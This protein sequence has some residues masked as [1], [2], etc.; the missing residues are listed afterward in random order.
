MMTPRPSRALVP[1]RA[2][3]KRSRARW[4]LVAVSFFAL[5]SEGCASLG[6]GNNGCGSGC[7]G[8]MFNFSRLRSCNLSQKLFHRRGTGAVVESGGCDPGL[9]GIPVEGGAP[10][11]VQPGP[12]LGTPPTDSDPNL[13]PLPS[14]SGTPKAPGDAPTGLNSRPGKASYQTQ[15]DR[16]RGEATQARREAAPARDPLADIPKLTASATAAEPSPPP[17]PDANE[18]PAPEKPSESAARPA[19]S[20]AG[21]G[22][23]IR[24]FK[25]V[26][27][28]RLAFGSL[29]NEDGWKWLA[30]V[31]YKTVIDLRPTSEVRQAEITA[32]DHHGLHRLSIPTPSDRIDPAVLAK[33]EAE[34]AR[35]DA[36]PIFVFDGDGVRAASIGYLHLALVRKVEARTAERDLDEMGAADTPLWKAALAHSAQ[37]KSASASAPQKDSAKPSDG[38]APSSSLPEVLSSRN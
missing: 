7:G 24:R 27:P 28:P 18:G 6:I 11:M 21:L 4:G 26:P 35:E 12:P 8:G 30:S 20:S 22:P 25:V 14:N 34:L 37:A 29:P 10:M 3:P 19:D 23:G 36:R 33:I 17:A 5:F 1:G 32:I 13:L 15:I 31:G 9:G 16:S 2:A 38:L